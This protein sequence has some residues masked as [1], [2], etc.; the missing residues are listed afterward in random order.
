MKDNMIKKLLPTVLV[1]S[2]IAFCFAIANTFGN[3]YAYSNSDCPDGWRYYDIVYGDGNGGVEI[4]ACT[5]T[6]DNFVSEDS[7]ELKN[8]CISEIE[9]FG[10]T[11]EYIG[12]KSNLPDDVVNYCISNNS[13]FYKSYIGYISRSHYEKLINSYSCYTCLEDYNRK[14]IWSNNTPG[15]S[16]LSS[17]KENSSSLDK[18]TCEKILT[19]KL[20]TDD[21]IMDEDLTYTRFYGEEFVFPTPSNDNYTFIGWSS[22]NCNNTN[23][24]AGGSNIL[25]TSDKE[26]IACY[27]ENSNNVNEVFKVTFNTNNGT[28]YVNNV[29]S[30]INVFET[31]LVNL[32]EYTSLKDNY[33]FTGWRTSN[34]S[35]DNPSKDKTINITNSLVLHAC[36]NKENINNPETGSELLYIAYLIAI[37]ALCYGFITCIKNKNN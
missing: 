6:W 33:E 2:F 32:I 30:S 25:V 27:D 19:I 9:S 15:D 7:E 10:L 18:N 21:G 4:D 36:Y 20:D 35:C 29:K 31:N 22:D 13:G 26:F 11:V 28:L 23:K 17:W 14:A 1:F 34:E 24:Y 16:C 5:K 37:S 8:Y 3:T 12:S